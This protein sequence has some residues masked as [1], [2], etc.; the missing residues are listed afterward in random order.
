MHNLLQSLIGHPIAITLGP[1]NITW[2]GLAYVTTFLIGWMWLNSRFPKQS[3][4][5]NFT[6][7]IIVSGII[8]A[9]IGY[10]IFAL[11]DGSL[12]PSNLSDLL[13]PN[14]SGLSWHGG[15]LV[16]ALVGVWFCR[17]NKL[18]AWKIADCLAPIILL[19]VVLIR[20]ANFINGELPGRLTDSVALGFSFPGYPGLRHPQMLYESA[21]ALVLLLILF[22]SNLANLDSRNPFAK[23]NGRNKTGMLFVSVIGWLT[24]SRFLIEWFREPS[25][26]ILKLTGGQ[27]LSLIT[28]ILVTI[29]FYKKSCPV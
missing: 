22:L 12:T 29:I 15:L 17:K 2:Y 28:L 14:I 21:A 11:V 13:H 6:V 24:I 25:I 23:V 5:D 27:W 1:L 9:R 4:V 20:F 10:G 18:D 16:A 26:I 7:I 19:G 3:W 8:G